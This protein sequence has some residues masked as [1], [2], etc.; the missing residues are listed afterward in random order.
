MNS[1]SII[2]AGRL[3]TALAYALSKKG[4]LI[5]SLSC[6]T[7]PSAQESRRIIGDGQPVTDNIQAA[8]SGQIVIIAVPDD[9]IK[10]VSEQLASGLP[11]WSHRFVFHCSGLLTSRVLAPL[12]NLGALTASIHPIQTFAEKSADPQVFT[13][14]YFGI[15]GERLSIPPS[16]VLIQKLGGKFILLKAKDKPL[17]HAACSIASNFLVVLLDTSSFLLQR[18]GASEAQSVEILF[19]LIQGTLQNVKKLDVSSALT[20]P[21]ERGDK[22]SIEQHISALKKFPSQAEV[23]MELARKALELAQN[24]K[25]LSPEKIKDLENLLAGK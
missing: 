14:S 4:Y 25:R 20:G 1:V 7:L 24:K 22:D 18:I 21:I 10:D 15:E 11:E 17:Y 5:K 3:G 12:K 9:R 13:E 8:K 23:Y 16:K 2:G 6:R 19:P